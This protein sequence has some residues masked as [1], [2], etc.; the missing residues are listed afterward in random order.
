MS[1]SW[2][3]RSSRA[4]S[5]PA[6][7][8]RRARPSLEALDGRLLLTIFTN[9]VNGQLQVTDNA[10]SDLVTLDHSG[11]NTLVNGSAIPDSQITAGILIRVGSGVGVEDK[12]NIR[13]TIKPVTVDGQF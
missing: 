8:G 7:R 11:T 6:S 3:Q 1:P 13:A 10:F 12:V 5:C 2:W 9:F 4:K